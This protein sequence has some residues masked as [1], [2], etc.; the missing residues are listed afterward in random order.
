[1]KKDQTFQHRDNPNSRPGTCPER[2]LCHEPPL[3]WKLGILP[4][5]RK[6]FPGVASKSCNSG[7][8]QIER[9]ERATRTS[10]NDLESSCQVL[11]DIQDV[12]VSS[13]C[14]LTPLILVLIDCDTWD[15]VVDYVVTG[16][17]AG[18]VVVLSRVDGIVPV[19]HTLKE[20]E[21]KTELER[22]KRRGCSKLGETE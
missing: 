19:C 4:P 1:M 20:E 10:I 13:F 18:I 14:A 15:R 17:D 22:V 11:F 3:D 7:R 12:D 9:I 8:G 2:L 21:E 6:I 16:A 5:V